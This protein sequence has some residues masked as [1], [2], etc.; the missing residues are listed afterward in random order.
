MTQEQPPEPKRIIEDSQRLA[1]DARHLYDTIRTEN[2]V[3]YY[4]N[5][6][7]YAFLAAAAGLGYVLGGGLFT[8]FTR[9]MIRVGF[10]A[11]ALPVA[12]KQLRELASSA[13]GDDISI[14]PDT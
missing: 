3:G 12:V 14:G 4:Y 2:P 10:K 11:M 5:K 1:N 7:P 9:R 8:P 6:N 13:T